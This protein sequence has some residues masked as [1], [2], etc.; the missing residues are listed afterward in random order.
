M[1]TSCVGTA[2]WGST[3]QNIRQRFAVRRQA[4]HP[5][6]PPRHRDCRASDRRI[7]P[8]WIGGSSVTIP[9]HS[10]HQ[11]RWRW[12]EARAVPRVGA[13][14]VLSQTP[15]PVVPFRLGC[16]SQADAVP[17]TALSPDIYET[18]RRD[19]GQIASNRNRRQPTSESCC[20]VT[21]ISGA[22]HVKTTLKEKSSGENGESG[23]DAV[24]RHP[25]A[26][27]L[28]RFV[29]TPPPLPGNTV[30]ISE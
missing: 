9:T 21:G 14:R 17:A 8:E 7:Q 30:R 25:G 1:E 15:S 3:P 28:A 6:A 29:A 18:R 19:T 12:R 22:L 4:L 5:T 13:T 20:T 10:P 26:G 23:R 16:D 11:S 2:Q 24:D 27:Q